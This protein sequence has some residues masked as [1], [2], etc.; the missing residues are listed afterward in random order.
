MLTDIE[1][2]KA[3]PREKSYRLFDGNGLYLEVL[4][5]GAK[6]WRLKYRY[7]GKEKRLAIGV[8]PQVTAKQAREKTI[9]AK[10][11]L[12]EGRDPSAERKKIKLASTVAAENSF[13]A[14]AR[15]WLLKRASNISKEHAAKTLTKMES[16][17]F[18][19]IGNRPLSEITAPE[20]LHTL[21]RVENRG[22][23]HTAKRLLQNAGQV[24]RYGVATG[25]CERDIT[26]D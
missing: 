9:E 22:A 8:Y 12:A 21:R 1:C 13:E 17:L 11:T 15:D 5:T 20:I 25:R 16:N 24:F 18:P 10:S 4:P 7:L 23:I 3:L 6:Y 26:T 2:K 19:W 14:T